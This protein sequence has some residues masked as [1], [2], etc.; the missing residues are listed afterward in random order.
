MDCSCISSRKFSAIISSN[1]TLLILLFWHYKMFDLSTFLC[2]PSKYFHLSSLFSRSIFSPGPPQVGGTATHGRFVTCSRYFQCVKSGWSGRV[3]FCR[4]SLLVPPLLVY[5]GYRLL[6]AALGNNCGA[7]LRHKT[8]MPFS[9]EDLHYFWL[10][11][12]VTFSSRLEV[13]DHPRLE[14]GLMLRCQCLH[15]VD[16]MFPWF[17]SAPR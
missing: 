9:R 8:K 7:L 16:G 17:G 6:C 4:P 2:L 10:V 13:S 12:T 3:D 15:F 14:F 5:L 11:L 1:N